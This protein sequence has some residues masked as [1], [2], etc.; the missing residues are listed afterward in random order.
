MTRVGIIASP[1]KPQVPA[2]LER[3]SRWLKG[4]AE[5]VC[6]ELCYDGRKA[7]D[8]GAE[9]IF[10][11]GGDGT[12]IRV[13]HS[14]A[15][16]Q[17]PL[18]GVNLGK[19]GFMADF[20]MDQ[21]E[22]DGA[23]LFEG[24]ASV[25]R[26]VMLNVQLESEDGAVFRSPA[27]NDCVVLNGPPYRIV[28]LHVEAD[29]DEVAVMRGDGLIVATASGSTAHNLSAGGPILEPTAEVFI[30]TPIC[31]HALTFRP[32]VMA[33]SRRLCVRT[34]Q[35]NA[36]TAIVVDGQTIR[37]F[38]DGDRLVLSRFNADFQL[39]RNPRHSAFR[40]LRRKLMWAESPKNED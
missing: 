32:L 37:P 11:L 7:V 3:L 30:L 35:A 4:R 24:Q 34:V 2:A 14:L 33:A 6:A 16:R 39:V 15:D 17:V 31:A 25:A 38:G 8:A 12:L 1:E 19:L 36:G 27:I 9:M 26:R 28:E 22:Q 18:I 5:L 21:I 13:A 40:A 10:V 29:G 23:F 20:T